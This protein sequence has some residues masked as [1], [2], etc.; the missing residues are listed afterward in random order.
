MLFYHGARQAVGAS[1]RLLAVGA[2]TLAV[3]CS[4]AMAQSDLQKFEATIPAQAKF[5][6]A[7]YQA[8]ALTT[9]IGHK[10]EPFREIEAAIAHACKKDITEAD[11]D[12]ARIGISAE[13]RAKSIERFSYLA[14]TERQLLYEGKTIPG[15]QEGPFTAQVM[16]C[17]R[18]MRA[19]KAVYL[20]CID[21]AVKALNPTSTDSS[22][23]V[24]DAAIGMCAAKRSAVVSSLMCFSMR[25]T[26]ANSTVSQL[27]RQLRSEALGKIAAARAGMRQI[28]RQPPK[29]TPATRRHDI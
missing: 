29:P 28:E 11:R 19:A 9:S 3:T 4:A 8:C 15:H 17:D 20:A 7:K 5:A 25:A 21:E 27:D 2:V 26:E 13:Q 10:G 23:V 6:F 14:M 1:L 22:D 24:A 12:L 16:R 18:K